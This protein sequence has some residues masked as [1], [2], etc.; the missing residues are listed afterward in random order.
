MQHALESQEI[1][2]KF[3][4]ENLMKEA[5]SDLGVDGTIMSKWILNE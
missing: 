3:E 2:T 4:S 5:I 1:N